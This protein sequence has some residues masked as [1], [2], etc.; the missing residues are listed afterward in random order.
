MS[1]SI[2]IPGP[3]KGA[4]FID[5]P[6][7]FSVRVALEPEETVVAARLTDPAAHGAL[8]TPG[9]RAWVRPAPNPDGSHEWSLALVQAKGGALVSLEP[10]MIHFLVRTSLE[11]EVFP[12]LDGWFLESIDAPLGRSRVPFQ[13]S[14]IAGEKMLLA[15]F[16]AT[17]VERGV[18]LYPDGPNEHAART[19]H[20]L[21]QVA[22]RPG[23]HAT[24]LFVAPRN[25]ATALAPNEV[26]D[27]TVADALRAAE[28][29]GVRLL[30]RRCQLTLTEAM[31]GVAIPVDPW[32]IPIR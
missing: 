12:E 9:N 29:G 31:L 22:A 7:R 24:A 8:L 26:A 21:I 19:L 18:A 2:P 32:D 17:R 11:Q 30:G 3:L 1:S 25:D 28:H 6:N 4:R 10:P 5:R 27:P 14:T 15:V 20:D 13:L 23:W 16:F